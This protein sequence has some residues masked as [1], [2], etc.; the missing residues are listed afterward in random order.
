MKNIKRILIIIVL[1]VLFVKTVSAQSKS[2]TNKKT[3]QNYQ[4]IGQIAKSTTFSTKSKTPFE[5]KLKKENVPT[6]VLESI[7]EDF[8]GLILEAIRAIPIVYVEDDVIINKNFNIDK[9]YDTY[10]IDLRTNNRTIIAMYDKSGKLLST[11][12]R[13]KSELLPIAVQMSIVK[14]YPGWII[15]KDSYLMVHFKDHK[16]KERYKLTLQ[17]GPKKVK[18]YMDKNGVILSHK[19]TH[20]ASKKVNKNAF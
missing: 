20:L 2:E 5:I 14:A 16:T 9:D 1:T 4:S 18:V 11:V 12:E 17:N 13:A 19:R 7:D 10:E 15:F 6:I 8:P 3:N